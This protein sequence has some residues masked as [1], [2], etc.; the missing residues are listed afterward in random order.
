[1]ISEV[2]AVPVAP[3]QKTNFYHEAE[4]IPSVISGPDKSDGISDEAAFKKVYAHFFAGIIED[5]LGGGMSESSQNL[6]EEYSARLY[7][8]EIAEQLVSDIDLQNLMATR[9][10]K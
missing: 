10:F 7:S 3:D 9:N 1:M 6:G 4:N 8:K 2:A 5:T